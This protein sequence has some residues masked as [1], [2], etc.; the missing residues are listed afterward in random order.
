MY[1]LLVSVTIFPFCFLHFTLPFSLSLFCWTLKKISKYLQLIRMA[2]FIGHRLCA[3][4]GF[5]EHCPVVVARFIPQT[6]KSTNNNQH[7]TKILHNITHAKAFQV[8]WFCSRWFVDLNHKR[9]HI[10]WIKH[11][12]EIAKWMRET[13]QEDQNNQKHSLTV[14]LWKR[15]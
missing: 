10:T 14:L 6:S 5:L 9:P 11:N 3:L 12:D 2:I 1:C 8:L 13:G 15:K 7:Q 4:L